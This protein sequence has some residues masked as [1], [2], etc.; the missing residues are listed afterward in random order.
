MAAARAA[1]GELLRFD[2]AKLRF[3]LGTSLTD[4]RIPVQVTPDA[5]AIVRAAA[6]ELAM[7]LLTSHRRFVPSDDLDRVCLQEGYANLPNPAPTLG[8]SRG[9]ADLRAAAQLGAAAHPALSG[10]I[11][12]A[13]MGPGGRGRSLTALFIETLRQASVEMEAREGEE[14]PLIV[15]LALFAELAAAEAQVRNLMPGPPIDRYLRAATATG[16]WIASRTGLERAARAADRA[17][18]DLL[19]IKLEAVL[20]PGAL[21]GQRTPLGG[22]TLYGCE[23][24]VPVARGEEMVTRLVQGRDPDSIVSSIT[25]ALGADDELS[26]RA[27]AAVAVARLRQLLYSGIALAE[28]GGFGDQVAGLR[29]M[30]SAPGALASTCTDERVRPTL[31]SKLEA[32]ANRLG[33]ESGAALERVGGSLR[34]WRHREPADCVGLT[35]SA[36]RGEYAFAAAALLCDVALE[37]L[38]GPARRTLLA[39]TGTEAA[40][41][42]EV[43]YEEGR[44]YRL[45]ARGGPILKASAHRPLGHLFADVKDFTRRTALLGPAAMA[46]FLRT[47]FYRPIL[48]AAKG[49]FSG[50]P[51]LSDRGGITVNNLLGDAISFSG[52]V[53]AMVALAAETRRLL[54]AYGARL[55]RELAS[56]AVARQLASIEA[57]YE[58]ELVRTE[59]AVREARTAGATAKAVWLEEELARLREERDRAMGRA[60]GEGLEA[61][62]FLSFGPA[63]LTILIDDEVFG[64]NRVAIAE[65]INES[66]RGTAR[67]QRAR[68]RADALLASQRA[69]TGNQSVQHAWSVFIEP[70]L[71]I[72]VPAELEQAA[73]VAARAGDIV[74]AMRVLSGPVREA[75]ERAAAASGDGAGDIFNSGAALSEEALTSFLEAVRSSRQLRHVVLEPREI[76][77]QLRARFFFGAAPLE[78]VATFLGDGRPAELFR[79]VGRAGFKGVGGVVVWELAA[80]TGGPAELFKQ[81][82][83]KW[84]KGP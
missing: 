17:S 4:V 18:A 27:E 84:L 76:P 63:P 12:C 59:S 43:E 26:R 56:E 66:A 53:E 35:R 45:S 57:R 44:L 34:A 7:L 49:F 78:L 24:A 75:V 70:P 54:L 42:A 36:A 61:G 79:R 39:R 31:A 72:E 23:L 38:L 71:A 29:D 80:D 52:D 46:E 81:F 50:M 1:G 10:G 30:Y 60:R 69:A 33:S 3:S 20:S 58:E 74:A 65:K 67:N 82:A 47:E 14:T 64:Q 55:E 2:P 5:T 37:R 68:G 73:M 11:V 62:L 13:W 77:D 8:P 40:G 21:L 48:S 15:A 83:A 6:T 28:S 51:H 22:A 9:G 19:Q 41:G 25:Q 16:L 32:L